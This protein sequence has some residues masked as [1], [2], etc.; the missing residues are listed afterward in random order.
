MY[1]DLNAI[2]VWEQHIVRCSISGL[3]SLN[4]NIG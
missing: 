3:L 1:F 4:S 2:N